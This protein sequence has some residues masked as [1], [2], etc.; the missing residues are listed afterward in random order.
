MSTIADYAGRT[1][2]LLAFQAPAGGYTPG[3]DQRLGQSLV[4][5]GDGGAVVTG[6]EKLFQRVLLTLLTR[7]GTVPFQPAVG[8]AFLDD[9]QSGQ[10]RTEA[11]VELSFYAAKLDLVRQVQGLETAADPADERLVTVDLDGVTLAGTHVT[12]NLTLV[13]AAGAGRTFIA[14]V[15]VVTRP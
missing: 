6:V 10:W 8:T 13:T 14:P 1:A 4:G 3:A 2:D 9:A 15:P 5:P 12:L 7:A 11:D